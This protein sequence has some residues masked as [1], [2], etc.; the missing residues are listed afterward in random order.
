MHTVRIGSTV[1]TTVNDFSRSIA[2]ERDQG[3]VKQKA[4]AATET[5]GRENNKSFLCEGKLIA[6]SLAAKTRGYY[7]LNVQLINASIICRRQEIRNPKR[8]MRLYVYGYE[9]YQALGNVDGK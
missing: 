7:L 5:S 1:A 8:G 4:N 6:T 3:E 2:D 9:S